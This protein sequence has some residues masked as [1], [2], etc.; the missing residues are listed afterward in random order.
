MLPIMCWFV[1]YWWSQKLQGKLLLS[2]FFLCVRA[3]SNV[4]AP[5]VLGYIV[6]FLIRYC[7][8]K[9]NRG[10]LNFCGFRGSLKPQKLKSNEIQFSHWLL[11]VMFEI[12]NSRTQRSL[13]VVEH[14]KLCPTNIS[15]FTVPITQEIKIH[16]YVII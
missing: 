9:S 16:Y 3:S 7:E 8:I 5:L 13:H 14:D 12:T 1:L 11:P 6:F 4:G 15:T 10:A 2:K